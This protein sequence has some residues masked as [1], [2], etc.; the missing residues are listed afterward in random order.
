MVNPDNSFEVLVDQTVVN[1]GSLLTDMTP[2]VNPPAEIEDPDDHKP[3]DWD[4][5]PKIQDPDAFKPEDWSV[6]GK[7]LHLVVDRC[8]TQLPQSFHVMCLCAGMR[9]LLLRFQMRMQ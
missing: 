4:E 1:S 8:F 7:Q 9:M 5:R 6:H 2:P 3:Q